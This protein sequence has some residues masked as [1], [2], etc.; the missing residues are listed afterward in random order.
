MAIIK[1][2]GCGKH[3]SDEMPACPYCGAPRP[4]VPDGQ[5]FDNFLFTFLLLVTL[6]AV[7]GVGMLARKKAGP[8]PPAL[9]S[10]SG[11]TN[12]QDDPEDFFARYGP[13]DIDDCA[14]HD[15][16]QTHTATRFVIYEAERVRLVYVADDPAAMIPPYQGW[17]F[18]AFQDG[19]DN[20][21]LTAA[22]V[23]QR[24]KGRITQPT[25]SLKPAPTWPTTQPV[26]ED[27]SLRR[28]TN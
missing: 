15:K 7:V 1:C 26:L 9:Q 27:Q 25:K 5:G 20:R 6:G 23:E 3:V 14:E 10:T 24:L 8:P 11:P 19:Q 21:I 17:K 16:P 28:I 2:H 13:P 22:E 12:P 18:V 4:R